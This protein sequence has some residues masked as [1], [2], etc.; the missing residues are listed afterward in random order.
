VIAKS[1]HCQ[2][3]EEEKKKKKKISFKIY[4]I[5]YVGLKKVI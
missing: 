3:E 1:D 5:H 2:E 4:D